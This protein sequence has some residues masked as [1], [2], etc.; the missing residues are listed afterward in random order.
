MSRLAPP[1][2]PS[3]PTCATFFLPEIGAMANQLY[4]PISVNG[5]RSHRTRIVLP[6]FEHSGEFTSLILQS[7]PP[8]PHIPSVTFGTGGYAVHGPNPLTGTF[9]DT[10]Q[11]N[12]QI[13]RLH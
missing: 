12:C 7:H 13:R 8:P 1:H 10:S 6:I 4:L 2:P 9:S 5:M 11:S 3:H